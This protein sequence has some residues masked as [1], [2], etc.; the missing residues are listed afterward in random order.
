M[1][2]IDFNNEIIDNIFMAID[3]FNREKARLYIAYELNRKDIEIIELKR[4]IE[5]LKQK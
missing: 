3:D 1:N 5:K 4:E 2:T